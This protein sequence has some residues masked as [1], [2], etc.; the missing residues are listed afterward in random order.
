MLESID[1][2]YMRL[3]LEEAVQAGKREEV[4]VGAVLVDVD[5]RLLAQ[6]GNNCI[7][8]SDPSGHAEIVVL[9]QAGR[10]LGNYRLSGATLYCTL[11]PCI[12]CVGAMIHARVTRLVFGALDPKTG[13]IISRYQIGTDGMLNHNLTVE[14]GLLADECGEL[15]KDFFSKRRVP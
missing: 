11:E 4:P 2:D 5:G 12:M 13:A 7:E 6:A 1:Y 3:A 15:L 8:Q 9:R 14:F 10:K